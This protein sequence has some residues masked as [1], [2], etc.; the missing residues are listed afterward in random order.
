MILQIK[1]EIQSHILPF[2]LLP[3]IPFESLL[4]GRGNVSIST[5]HLIG[6]K[7][8]QQKGIVSLQ[9]ALTVIC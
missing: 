2:Q 7:E 4:V 6:K 9:R 8:D 5:R 1:Y 3:G